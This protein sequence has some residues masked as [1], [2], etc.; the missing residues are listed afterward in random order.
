MEH[1]I[2]EHMTALRVGAQLSLVDRDE[3]DVALH[4]HRFGGAQ[5]PARVLRQ[6]LLLAGDQGDPAGALEL[7]DPIV[8]LAREQA[9]RKADHPGG[10]AAH[11]LD[12]EMGLAGVGRAEDRLELG[13]HRPKIVARNAMRNLFR[14]LI[15]AAPFIRCGCRFA[16][17]TP[18]GQTRNLTLTSFLHN[19]GHLP[20]GDARRG[21]QA[22]RRGGT[23]LYQMSDIRV[24]SGSGAAALA[25]D[26]GLFRASPLRPAFGQKAEL[27]RPAT[28]GGFDLVVDLGQR[29]GSPEWLRGFATCFG[30]CYAAWSLAPG[31]Q[32]LPGRAPPPLADAQFEEA[33]T[34]AVS[35]LAYGGDTGRRMAPTDAVE[36]LAESPERPIIDLRATFGRGDGFASVLERAGVGAAE[37]AQAAALIG[38]VVPVAEIRPGTLMDMILGRRPNRM[39]A[40]PLDKLAFRARFD[41]RIELERVGGALTL[42]QIPISIDE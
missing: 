42:R 17:T 28:G 24:G 1:A 32:P 15:G 19:P 13:I 25:L 21:D 5:E 39:V 2:G 20:S 10:V 6:D 29:I 4:R 40:R 23:A 16:A 7:R 18:I 38:G 33:R 35:P 27:R 26:G 31:L 8:D 12:R 22:A 37:A 34:L 11:P 3:S 41:L 30:L 36:P 9:Q 14:R